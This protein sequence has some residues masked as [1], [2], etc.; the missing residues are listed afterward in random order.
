MM[1]LSG[2]SLVARILERVLLMNMG[3]QFLRV[4]RAIL[5]IE[6]IILH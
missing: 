5:S 4:L 2:R 1:D 6:I 3:F